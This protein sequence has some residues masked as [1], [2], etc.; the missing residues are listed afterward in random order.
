MT[1]LDNMI[2]NLRTENAELRAENAELKRINEEL[3][4]K[5]VEMMHI[6]TYAA[7]LANRKGL[8]LV[9]KEVE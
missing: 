4:T 6:A 2:F 8:V 3:E 1:I 9:K 5:A 7:E